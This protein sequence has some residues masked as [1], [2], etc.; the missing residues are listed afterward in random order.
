MALGFV[1]DRP[2][3][4]QRVV[5]AADSADDLY[6]MANLFPDDTGLPVTVWVSPRGRA[7]HAARIK[8]CRTAG[9]KMV[10]TNTAVV[11][12]SAEPVVVVGTLPIRYVEP[13]AKWVASNRE[14]LLEYWV[15]A[16]GTGALLRKLK[17]LGRVK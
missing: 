4:R 10:P 12:I 13:V 9:N 16:I 11:S 8:V 3:K 17:R 7:R 14:A 1:T 15:G 5:K 2:S 6:E